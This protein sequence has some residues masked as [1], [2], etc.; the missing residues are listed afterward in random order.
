[1]RADQDGRRRRCSRDRGPAKTCARLLPTK[2]G[3]LPR[4]GPYVGHAWWR[5]T[6]MGRAALAACMSE[7]GGGGG[8]RLQAGNASGRRWCATRTTTWARWSTC[9][10]SPRP[11]SPTTARRSILPP[12]PVRQPCAYKRAKQALTAK[13]LC[14]CVCVC[15]FVCAPCCCL[16]ISLCL[17]AVCWRAHRR[18]RGSGAGVLQH[19]CHLHRSARL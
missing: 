16:S 13:C 5:V 2:P 4:L 11:H 12:R 18:S 9:S 15:L 3:R 14:V 7:G 17:C 6:M 10:K 8:R 1:V 19:G